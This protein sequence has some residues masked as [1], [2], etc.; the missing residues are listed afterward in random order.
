M[1]KRRGKQI[2]RGRTFWEKTVRE[3]TESGKTQAAFAREKGLK[4]TTFGR[5]VRLLR[6]KQEVLIASE[7]IEIVSS[8]PERF[9]RA[10]G[11]TKLK[12]GAA[13]VEFS[14]LPPLPYLTALLREVCSC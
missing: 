11:E 10:E 6:P 3:F 1:R 4:Q 12:V 2:H 9:Q 14:D 5:W 8:P 13:T 7:L